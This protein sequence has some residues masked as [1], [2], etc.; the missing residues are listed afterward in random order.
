LGDKQIFGAKKFV[1]NF[2]IFLNNGILYKKN[3]N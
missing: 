2:S 3:K 1:M